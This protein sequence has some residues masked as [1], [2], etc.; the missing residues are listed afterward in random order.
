MTTIDNHEAYAIILQQ[1]FIKFDTLM[2]DSEFEVD[3]IYYSSAHRI[4]L[5][6]STDI[7]TCYV[8]LVYSKQ[9]DYIYETMETSIR[10]DNIWDKDDVD[11][12]L[13]E[14][15]NLVSLKCPNI[16]IQYLS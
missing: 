4:D 14:L 15:R 2:K 7:F 12:L 10:F 11:Q 3:K 6:N 8:N 5:F 1:K 16:E 9:T 13:T